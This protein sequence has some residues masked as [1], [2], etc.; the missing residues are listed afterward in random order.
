MSLYKNF[1]YVDNKFI[2]EN[3]YLK[4]N[5]QLNIER[6]L[7]NCAAFIFNEIRHELN[8]IEIDRCRNAKI[9]YMFKSYI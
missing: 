5:N 2:S 6:L 7:N 3:L 4:T 8:G 9:S 1:F